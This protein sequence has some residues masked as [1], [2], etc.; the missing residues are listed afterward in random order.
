[1]RN[2]AIP[3]PIHNPAV[4]AAHDELHEL[5]SGDLPELPSVETVDR[6][7]DGLIDAIAHDRVVTLTSPAGQV[8]QEDVVAC[9]ATFHDATA[10]L[11][12]FEVL[13]HRFATCN[14]DAQIGACAV[15]FLEALVDQ[16]AMALAVMEARGAT[17]DY[18]QPHDE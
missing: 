15:D 2:P 6:H 4:D 9:L 18:S 17:V 7:F 12:A 3:C 5:R 10:P 16:A 13:L 14:D 11:T 1:M 8:L